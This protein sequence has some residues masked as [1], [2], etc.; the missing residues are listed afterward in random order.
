MPF[1]T[2][3]KIGAEWLTRR[4]ALWALANV[5]CQN[6]GLTGLSLAYDFALNMVKLLSMY[7]I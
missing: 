5:W 1:D 3:Q 2:P 4:L 7:L 6:I